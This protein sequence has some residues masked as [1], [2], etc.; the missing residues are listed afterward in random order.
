[1]SI[2]KR[3]SAANISKYIRETMG[4]VPPETEE[5][6]VLIAFI[7]E[8]NGEVGPDEDEQKGKAPVGSDGVDSASGINMKD[9]VNILIPKTDDERG[10][11]D[12]FVGCNGAGF[13][14]KRGVRAKVPRAVLG[15]LKD[16]VTKKLVEVLKENGDSTGAYEYV[17]VPTYNY[18][19]VD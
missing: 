5:K 9:R 4:L 16:A 7:K 8:N 6:D 11:E 10:S 19:I 13:L 14:I 17:D 18:Q 15:V 1:M 12:V 3:A 2:N